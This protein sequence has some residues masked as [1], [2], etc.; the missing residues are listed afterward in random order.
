MESDLGRRKA[1]IDRNVLA[2][3]LRRE[4][5]DLK[6]GSVKGTLPK[7]K[8]NNQSSRDIDE[9]LGRTLMDERK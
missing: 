9:F 7:E 4:H 5:N 1:W 3:Q 8:K 2:K 6:I